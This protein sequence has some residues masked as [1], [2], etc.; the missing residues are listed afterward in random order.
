VFASYIKE[1]NLIELMR[2]ELLA[3]SE[4][5]KSAVMAD[6]DEESIAFAEQAKE[7]VAALDAAKSELGEL[8]ARL[9][10]SKEKALLASF[11]LAWLEYRQLD[12]E[13]LEL[14]VLNTNLKAKRLLH[15]PCLTL[16]DQLDEALA[17]EKGRN[18]D[19]E[20]A[21]AQTLNDQ[22]LI[23]AMKIQTL[24]APHIESPDALVM[25]AL[26]NR[27]H[28]LDKKLA[29]ALDEFVAQASTPE[30]KAARG[31][32]SRLYR[33]YTQQTRQILSL[34]RRNSNVISLSLSLGQKRKITAR[35]LE[36]IDALKQ[37]ASNKEF[38]AT[39]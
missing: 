5:E 38:K 3:A 36:L 17:T 16:L 20:S 14:A 37:L 33:E 2:N 32:A 30:T 19:P 13:I 12:K 9:D 35:C 11:D 8:V 15:G 10:L 29:K 18:D 25:D 6:T 4:A 21:R 24:L 1:R 31:E 27:I 7:H 22:I 26:E 39:R 23:N 34:S 28:A